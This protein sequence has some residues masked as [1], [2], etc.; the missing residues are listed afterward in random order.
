MSVTPDMKLT[1][2]A[3]P[4]LYEQQDTTSNVDYR[5][6]CNKTNMINCF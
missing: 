1:N 3:R 6:L 5:S 4:L 2:D